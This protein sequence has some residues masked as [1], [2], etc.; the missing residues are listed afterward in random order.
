MQEKGGGEGS[1]R[2]HQQIHVTW[3]QLKGKTVFLPTSSGQSLPNTNVQHKP[4][5]LRDNVCLFQIKKEEEA[6]ETRDKSR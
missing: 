6:E 1:T 4:D 5:S 3:I 2:R